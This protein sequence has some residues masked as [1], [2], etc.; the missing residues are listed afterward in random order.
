MIE[1]ERLVAAGP[2]MRLAERLRASPIEERFLRTPK[3]VRGIEHMILSLGSFEQVEGDEARH[4]VEMAVALKP[5]LLEVGF[6]AFTHFEAIHGN[7][8][9]FV[10]SL[11]SPE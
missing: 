7:E 1:I 3:R 10:P 9:T 5:N 2:G 11:Q 6:R 8:H 4:A